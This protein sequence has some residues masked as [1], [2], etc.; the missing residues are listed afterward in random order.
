[1]GLRRRAGGLSRLSLHHVGLRARDPVRLGEAAGLQLGAVGG[2]AEVKV[3]FGRTAADY[4]RHRAGYPAVFFD[5]LATLGVGLPGQ[6][7]LDLGT[8][9]GALA[10]GLA[11]RGA[12]VTGIDP[13]AALLDEARALDRAAGVVVRYLQG[14]AEST[15]LD[16]GTCDAITASQCWHWFERPRAA[17]EAHRLLVPSGRL[18]LTYL[19][20]IAA[21]GGVAHATEELILAHN[22]RW[23][24][25]R[26]AGS[27]IYPEWE[28]DL[29]RAGFGERELI[30]LEVDVP[31]SHAAW[32]GRIRA[33]AGIGACLPDD[34]VAKF[35]AALAALLVDR[36]PG[37][38][39]AVPHR[40]FA[41][42]VR[43]LG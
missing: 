36:F 40:A 37:E 32:R 14:V 6:R 19:D 35:D 33:S 29:V 13:S 7:V 11:R 16:G 31:Y 9:T 26:R 15:L 38:P 42:V 22:P 12:L 41:L 28:E 2:Q 30:A 25:L 24:D 1:M 20:W 21:P 23:E 10:R 8:G 5:R 17:A 4:A 34:A 39:L 43:R 18:A 27:E 3:D